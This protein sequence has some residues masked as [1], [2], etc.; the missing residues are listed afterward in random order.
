MSK[1]T[2]Q[3]YTAKNYV[4]ALFLFIAFGLIFYC[5]VDYISTPTEMATDTQVWT[6]LE[7]RGYA[8]HDLTQQY[9]EKEPNCGILKNIT[10]QN[11]DIVIEFFVYKND[12][13]ADSVWAKYRS[14]IREKELIPLS[15]TGRGNKTVYQTI[16][17]DEKY[18]AVIQVGNTLV[19]ATGN[20]ESMNDINSFLVSIGYLTPSKPSKPLSNE[21][22]YVIAIFMYIIVL[23]PL[24]RLS[25][26][27]IWRLICKSA[28]ITSK[29]LN[30]YEEETKHR[31]SFESTRYAYFSHKVKEPKRF[32][33]MYLAYK[34]GFL[35]LYIAIFMNFI[36]IFIDLGK[37]NSD[38][39]GLAAVFVVVASGFISVLYER[40]YLPLHK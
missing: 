34:A 6:E 18:Y 32:K 24:T 37:I 1:Q 27:W 28:E 15:V 35:P 19:Y 29:D 20:E 36:S 8:P 10:V 22:R 7:T 5:I 26:R 33:I 17:D 3:K 9:L 39:F 38:I 4:F 14:F 23:L 2:R 16:A 31:F 25:L 40:I 21:M 11:D 30:L 12:K 13:K